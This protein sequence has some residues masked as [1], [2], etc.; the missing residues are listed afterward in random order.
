MQDEY[1][2]LKENFEALVQGQNIRKNLIEIKELI[3]EEDKKKE[4][5]DL[6]ADS[7]IFV[8]LLKG[9]DPKVRK[10]TALILGILE[11]QEA[12][13]AL[14]LTYESEKTLFVRSAYLTAMQK[15]DCT[16]YIEALQERYKTLLQMDAA[17]E[18]KK[19]IRR[20]RKELE[21]ILRKE[22]EHH[23]H[24]FCGYETESEVI[25]T[26][27]RGFAKLTEEQIRGAKTAVSLSGVRVKTKNLS[28]I[29]KIRTF[30]EILF[31]IQ[32]KNPF[33]PD[34]KEAADSILK[35]GLMELLKQHLEG[36]APYYF[37][38]QVMAPMENAAKA[39]FIKKTAYALEEAG[40]YQLINAKDSYEIEIRLIQN[41]DGLFQAYLKFYTLPL[42]RFAYRKNVLPVSIHP[43]QAALLL[44][45]AK[46]YLKEDAA[47]LDPFCGVGT[48]LLEREQILPARTLYGIDIFGD[49]IHGARE[50]TELAKAKV[51]YI[52]RDFFDFTHR[53]K[54]DEILTNMPARGKKSKEEQDAFY[55]RFFKK[56]KEHLTKDGTIIM[57]TNENGFV[58]KQLRL[59]KDMKLLGEYCIRQKEGYFLFIIGT[60]E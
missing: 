19:H 38:I 10:N 17:E 52:Q 7:T 56:A 9:E 35:G 18:E 28:P 20:E 51:S 34:A 14:F 36:E 22:E 2:M 21:N 54:F 55:G 16:E 37:R 60:K 11:K 23:F 53:H 32:V 41:K 29:L 33:A 5:L 13:P 26:T 39:E 59:N 45:L 25:L 27:D 50:N 30:R 1:K 8:D 4:L 6:S 12:L 3:K 57:Y 49:A 46:P 43:T 15:L 58:K 47:V 40:G 24:P 42:D 44:R 31:P 48:M